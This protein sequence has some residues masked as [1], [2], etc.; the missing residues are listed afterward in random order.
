MEGAPLVLS[1]DGSIEGSTV[2][3]KYQWG[4]LHYV[5]ERETDITMTPRATAC[6]AISIETG[7]FYASSTG[8]KINKTS[9]GQAELVAAAKGLQQ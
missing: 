6:I 4:S 7:C 2:D 8:Y 1:I 5:S 9:S 3:A